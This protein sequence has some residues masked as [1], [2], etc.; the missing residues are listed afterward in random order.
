MYRFIR[1]KTHIILMK[2][3][4]LFLF[5]YAWWY[6]LIWL[7]IYKIFTQDTEF[8]QSSLLA[9]TVVSKQKVVD[10][11]LPL[12]CDLGECH[13]VASA[14]PTVGQPLLDLFHADAG[15]LCEPLGWVLAQ[16]R[17]VSITVIPSV[18]HLQR[19]R[20]ELPL[21]HSAALLSLTT[22]GTSVHSLSLE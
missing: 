13:G 18:Q 4:H 17:I 15:W 14:H 12:T 7:Y 5:T 11:V 6:I 9:L 20:T 8:V 1:M 2:I 19:R 21:P 16:V 10:G 22:G 3:E